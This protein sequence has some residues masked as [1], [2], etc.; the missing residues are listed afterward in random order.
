MN[1][2]M[3]YVKNG[4]DIIAL[5]NY[6]YNHFKV[7]I[8]KNLHV[9]KIFQYSRKQLKYF[10]KIQKKITKSPDFEDSSKSI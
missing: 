8:S 5:I 10:G 4:E 6:I 9:V 1:V 2:E 7:V 3:F